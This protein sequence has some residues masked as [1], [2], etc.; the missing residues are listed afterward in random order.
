MLKSFFHKFIHIILLFL[1]IAMGFSA[2]YFYKKANT[3]NPGKKVETSNLI[4]KISKHV[5]LPN[6]E[7]PTIATVA[8][9]NL[10]KDQAFFVDTLVG[11][12]VLMYT[13][14]KKAILYRPSIDRVI[15]ITVI[16]LD[17]P[18]PSTA[19]SSKTNATTTP[20]TP[21]KKNNK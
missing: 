8:D 13:N 4:E 15:N 10:L 3:V 2:F 17:S 20:K 18:A 6:G 9:P 5:L 21:I 11:D 19:S 12:K 14:G 16:D 1:V 7:T